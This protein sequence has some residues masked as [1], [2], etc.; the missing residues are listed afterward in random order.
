MMDVV[1]M[2]KKMQSMYVVLWKKL[3]GW[4]LFLFYAVHY[5]LLFVVLAHFVFMPFSEAGKDFIWSGDGVEQH[6][7][8]LLYILSLIHIS[9]P[10]RP[11]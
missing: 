7:M 3:T 2:K 1:L 11:Y 8:R 5:T 10:T 4:R 6:F 9:E